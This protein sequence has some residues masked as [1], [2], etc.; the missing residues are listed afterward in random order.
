[1]KGGYHKNTPLNRYLGIRYIFSPVL[2]LASGRYFSDPTIAF[3]AIS[4][5]LLLDKRV[6][7]LR[8]EF[9]RFNLL[10]YLLYRPAKLGYRIKEIPVTRVY[11]D[12]ASVPTKIQG[13]SVLIYVLE[14][15]KVALGLYDP[16]G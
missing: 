14:M 16:K 5:K 9:V 1:M 4:R 2:S 13:I 15:F 11:P 7:P 8:K 12:D 6:L 10:L 3:K